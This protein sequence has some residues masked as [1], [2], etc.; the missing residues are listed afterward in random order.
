[1]SL[2]NF[3]IRSKRSSI[4]CSIHSAMDSVNQAL[5]EVLARAALVFAALAVLALLLQRLRA[6]W[7]GAVGERRVHRILRRSFLMAHTD[8]C[9]ATGQ[10]GLTQ[11]DHLALTPHGILVVE[12]KAYAGRVCGDGEDRYWRQYLG[13]R[14]HRLYN[15]IWQNAGHMRAV[16]HALRHSYPQVPVYG[17]VVFAGKAKLRLKQTEAVFTLRELKRFCAQHRRGA[18]PPTFTQAWHLLEA[19]L[20]DD[21]STRQAHLKQ[22]KRKQRALA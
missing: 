13:Q 8:V 22:V 21:A 17:C 16:R 7:I 20:R 6:R 11:I 5:H 12:T 4:E 15:P 1:M 3:A 9:L 14:V 10:G 18:I 19:Q 2:R